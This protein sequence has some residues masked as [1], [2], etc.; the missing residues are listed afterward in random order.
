M[1]N[2][3]NYLITLDE[4]IIASDGLPYWAVYGKVTIHKFEDMFGFKQTGHANWMV[5]VCSAFPDRPNKALIG[6][7]RAVKNIQM[8]VPPPAVNHNKVTIDGTDVYYPSVYI[9]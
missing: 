5:E 2:G 6:G 4:P 1:I 9:L 8:D 3:R 7:C